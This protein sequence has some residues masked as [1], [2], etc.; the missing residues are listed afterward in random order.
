[1]T[2]RTIDNPYRGLYRTF[3]LLAFGLNIFAVFGLMSG[4]DFLKTMVGIVQVALFFGGVILLIKG[5]K[6]ANTASAIMGGEE[7]LAHW[8]YPHNVWH[9]FA[10]NEVQRMNK[11]TMIISAALVCAGVV[12]GATGYNNITIKLGTV[13]GVVLGL[14][15]YTIGYF[16]GREF[17]KRSNRGPFDCFIAT[18]GVFINNILYSWG[19]RLQNT[20]ITQN[21]ETPF[22]S[23]AFTYTVRGKYGTTEKKLFI[24]IPDGK[25]KEAHSILSSLQRSQ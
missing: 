19:T 4:N 23:L 5:R 11:N 14:L 22:S 1:M 6:E 15:S 17:I 18:H 13:I 24:P 12:V 9:S 21:S 25:M 20:T 10:R 8:E 16:Y 3:I 2:Q 7:L